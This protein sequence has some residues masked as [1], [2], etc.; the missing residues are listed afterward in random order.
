MI[1]RCR[2]VTRRG[3]LGALCAALACAAVGVHFR[4]PVFS[5]ARAQQSGGKRSMQFP[6]TVST[7][8]RKYLEALPDPAT[9]PV[10]PAPDDLPAWKRAWE[11]NER[12]AKPKVEAA[13]KRY[14]PTIVERQLGG[15]REI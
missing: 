7:A 4:W 6:D 15:V 11:A 3:L 8:A 9:L 2:T 10:F 13:L 5:A 14:Q 1:H 12:A